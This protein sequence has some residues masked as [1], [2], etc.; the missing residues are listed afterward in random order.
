MRTLTSAVLLLLCAA[1]VV[2]CGDDGGGSGVAEITTGI[3]NAVADA[4]GPDQAVYASAEIMLPDPDIVAGTLTDD[5]NGPAAANSLNWSPKPPSMPLFSRT[6][7]T[8]SPRT[9]R[10][11][12]SMAPRR[13]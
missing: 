5:P 10:S 9:V 4:Q 2:G 7:D 13:S 3:E 1:L 6:D 8:G 12:P 11:A